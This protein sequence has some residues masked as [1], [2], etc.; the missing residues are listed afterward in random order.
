M[1]HPWQAGSDQPQ[2]KYN[3]IQYN[4]NA[5][6]NK[7]DS[8]AILQG[9]AVLKAVENRLIFILDLKVEYK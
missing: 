4:F 7:V 9:T 1:H 3:I 2:R 5:K 8:E 6:C